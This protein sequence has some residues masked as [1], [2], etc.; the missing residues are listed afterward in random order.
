LGYVVWNRRLFCFGT[1]NGSNE[2]GPEVP[3][4]DGLQPGRL[5]SHFQ[6]FKRL[7]RDC[8]AF[9][10]KIPK[11][12]HVLELNVRRELNADQELI[13]DAFIRAVAGTAKA[14]ANINPRTFFGW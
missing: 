4:D 8:V 7:N 13:E 11:S 10:G 1:R 2:L 6:S 5:A 9:S 12:G 14:F 3:V